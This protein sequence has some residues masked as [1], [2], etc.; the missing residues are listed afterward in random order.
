MVRSIRLRA[1]YR[2]GQRFVA[3]SAV[4]LVVAC[5]ATPPPI[6]VTAPPSAPA[7]S[8][9]AVAPAASPAAAP[10]ASPVAPAAS[11]VAPS[12]SPAAAVA[13]PS[14][15]RV[16][17]GPAVPMY[18][19]DA[20]HTGRSAF[21]GPRRLALVRTFDANQPQFLPQDSPNHAPDFQS[22]A[23]VGADGTIYIG[24]HGG[25]FFALKDSPSA[26]DR[27]DL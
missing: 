18:Q 12:A 25:T 13:S 17:S 1:L 14:P 10:A 21:P 8:K 22:S 4:G 23:S 19:V 6:V 24:F 5:Q 7:T 2:F 20:Q 27:L 16:A 15:A 26:R 11:P 3:V 9:P